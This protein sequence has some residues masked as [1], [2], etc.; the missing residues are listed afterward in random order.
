MTNVK[1]FPKITLIM[2]LFLWLVSCSKQTFVHDR[3]Y[4]V[5]L[6][7]SYTTENSKIVF[8]D[9]EGEKIKESAVQGRIV[10]SI[11]PID[12]TS[13]KFSILSNASNKIHS[14][15]EY[16]KV[17]S[18]DT[19]HIPLSQD[20]AAG[21]NVKTFQM[22]LKTNL[23]E[24][25]YKERL[26]Q[27]E[28]DGFLVLARIHN[29]NIY[30]VVEDVANVETFIHLYSIESGEKQSEFKLSDPTFKDMVVTD[31]VIIGTS[32]FKDQLL[33]LNH[34]T[35][36]ET[37]IKLNNSPYKLELFND[38]LYVI[39]DD[40]PVVTV[41]NIN[42]LNDFK[43][44]ETKY[45]LWQIKSIGE[46]IY[47]LSDFQNNVKYIDIYHPKN[48]ELIKTIEVTSKKNLYVMDIQGFTY[49]K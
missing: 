17:T 29:G 16:S 25:R 11:V 35:G 10:Q 6:Y 24:W 48:M 39:Y 37:F 42:N 27:K 47:T 15:E 49:K 3:D 44:F 7:S 9:K 31:D 1:Y 12:D 14:I 32:E 8:I 19:E 13:S 33:I 30:V 26:F 36:E 5:L 21:V 4:L 23:L 20:Y 18:E 38:Y 46:F 28:I 22:D 34:K 45:L 41:H 43:T 40:S 2:M